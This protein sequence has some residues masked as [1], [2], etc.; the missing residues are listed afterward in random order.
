MHKYIVGLTGASG[1]IYGI[2]L[3]EQLLVRSHEVHV[4]TSEAASIVA[5]H[6]MGYDGES[7]LQKAIS[8]ELQERLFIYD[9]SHI[10]AIIASGSFPNEGMIIV[11][12]SMA[13]IAGITVG[14]SRNLIE[15]AADVTLKEKRR[16]IVVPR[17]TPLSSIHLKNLLAL[18]N[19]GVHVIPAMPAFYHH[20]Q[21]LDDMVNF[22][23]GKIMDALQIPHELFRRYEGMD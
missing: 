15:R 12:S 19:L 23:V 4:V 20:P 22:V 5:K 1:I 7:W 18:S 13:T 10:S 8:P 17:E 3:V 9:N 16:L 2:R 14:N 21:S 11:P 6:E